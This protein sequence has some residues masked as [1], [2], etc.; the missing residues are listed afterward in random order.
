MPCQVCLRFPAPTTKF[1]ELE[2]NEERW[3]TLYRC[4]ACGIF[5][6]LIEMERA[7]RFSPI[8]ELRKH[9]ECCRD[10]ASVA[11]TPVPRPDR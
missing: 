1:E 3:G 9:Y 5:F 10:Q 8:E 6:E 4:K 2:S 11:G 7:P